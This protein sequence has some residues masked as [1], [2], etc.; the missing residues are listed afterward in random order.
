[1]PFLTDID[2]RAAIKGSRDPLGL[3]PVWARFGRTVVGNLT[4]VSNSVRGFTTTLLGYYF[5]E[6]AANELSEPAKALDYFLKFEQLAGYSRFYHAGDSQFR[7]T[8]RVAARLEKSRTVTIGASPREQIL[9]NQK[10]YGLWGLFSVPT[11]ESGML[12][13]RMLSR[14]ARE[15]VEK[16]YIKPLATNGVRGDRRIVDLLRRERAEVHL[17]GRDKDVTSRI[18][19]LLS[20]SISGHERSFYRSYLADGGDETNTDGNQPFLAKLLAELQPGQPFDGN[21]LRSTIKRAS[22]LSGG[23]ILAERLER[24]A[25]L[26]SL[27]VPMENAFWF[28][29]SRDGRTID[30]VANEIRQTWGRGLRHIDPDSIASY[31]TTISKAYQDDLRIASRFVTVANAFVQGDFEQALFTL[32]DH[33]ADVMRLRNGSQPWARLERKKVDV[34][35]RDESGSLIPGK[36]LPTRWRNTYFINSLKDVVMELRDV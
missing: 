29:L 33:N 32:L 30:S 34:R 4:T 24:I 28:L 5:A 6:R 21:E 12:L 31:S 36:E 13:E 7:G 27:L 3:V 1:M 16:T 14:T 26:E 23:D 19:T 11:R 9:G 18:A 10:T 35:Y 25:K 20:L 2:S 17:N 8:E 22:K 15:F